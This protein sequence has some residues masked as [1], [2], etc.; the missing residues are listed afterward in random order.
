MS[1]K[2]RPQ[3][4]LA[5]LL[6]SVSPVSWVAALLWGQDKIELNRRTQRITYSCSTGDYAK[7]TFEGHLLGV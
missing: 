6:F 5:E 1:G 2:K 3:V 4:G 7:I